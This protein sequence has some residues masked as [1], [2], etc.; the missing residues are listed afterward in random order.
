[1]RF[2]LDIVYLGQR[3]QSCKI[4]KT[5]QNS[6]TGKNAASIPEIPCNNK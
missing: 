6:V 2:D 4:V 1:M 3:K 5:F